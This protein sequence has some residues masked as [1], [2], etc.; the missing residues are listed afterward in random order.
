MN[1]KK[2]FTLIEVM[3]VLSVLAIIAILA[4]N[5][6]GSTMKEAVKSKCKTE[7]INKAHQYEEAIAI[8]ESKYGT[9]LPNILTE[10]AFITYFIDTGILKGLDVRYPSEGCY[11]PGETSYFDYRVNSLDTGGTAAGDDFIQLNSLPYDICV[12][13]HDENAGTTG[14]YDWDVEGVDY[15]GPAPMYC[16]HWADGTVT[17]GKDTWM[18]LPVVRR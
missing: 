9:T 8:Y 2:G 17:G 15:T 4:Y 5:F 14:G 7:I 13:I 16:E 11:I 10:A 6:F 18:V 1:T 12:E 3:V